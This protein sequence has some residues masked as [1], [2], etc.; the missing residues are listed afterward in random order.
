VRVSAV[1]CTHNPRAPYLKRVLEALRTQ[2]LPLADWE[3]LLVDNASTP[4]LAESWDVSWHPHGRYVRVDTLGVIHAR[5]A[6]LREAKGDIMV[7]V[8]DDNVLD[9]DY[10]AEAAR[11]MEQWPMIGVFGTGMSM[12]EFEVPPP[13]SI[14]PYL[15]GIAVRQ[16]DQDYFCNVPVF[17]RAIPFGAGMTLRRRVAEHFLHLYDTVPLRKFLGRA[18]K[19]MGSGEDDDLAFCAYD[20]HL[21]TARFRSLKLTHLI[22][23]E[24]LNDDYFVRLNA[25][26]A[27]SRDVLHVLWHRQLPP[28]DRVPIRQLRYWYNVWKRKG[29]ERRIFVAAEKQRAWV[30]RILREA[31]PTLR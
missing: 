15:A 5:A 20:L 7:F 4:P 28:L 18:G 27:R 3:L 14:K 23:K 11:L 24:R 6:G 10:L 21:G 26:F 29:L 25:G 12:G 13:E 9:P 19:D 17:T 22:P 1:I 8:D 2:T 30:R 16:L 31:D